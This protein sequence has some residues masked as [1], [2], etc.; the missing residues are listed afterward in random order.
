MT[1]LPPL[2]AVIC[3]EYDSKG[4]PGYVAHCMELGI[5][6]Q[7][8][9]IEEARAMLQEAVEGILE[10][11]TPEHIAQRIEEGGHAVALM[12]LEVQSS[13]QEQVAA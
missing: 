5:A 8:D 12:Q 2:T 7:G 10:A 6:S 1:H 3:L 4:A 13:M 9:T 11:S